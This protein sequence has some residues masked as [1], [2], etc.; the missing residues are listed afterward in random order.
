MGRVSLGRT[1]GRRHRLTGWQRYPAT[2]GRRVPMIQGTRFYEAVKVSN[3]DLQWVGYAEESHGW[4]LAKTRVDFLNR[5]E[6]FLDQHIG[7]TV[8]MAI[9]AQ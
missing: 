6:R 2:T 8:P 7:Q 3:P 1:F 5:V 9:V 4:W